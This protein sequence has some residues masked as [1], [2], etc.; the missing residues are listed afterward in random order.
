[1][2]KPVRLRQRASADVDDAIDHY[3]ATA[4]EGVALAFI[5]A[6]ERTLASIS[7]HPRLG[8]LRFAFELD[9]P[10]LRARRLGKFPYIAF[11]VERD[12]EVAVW[13]VLHSRRDITATMSDDDRE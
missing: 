11:Y 5:D 2:A 1:M 13:R 4:N 9:I 3:L 6:L 8:T 10:E 12:T 7:R